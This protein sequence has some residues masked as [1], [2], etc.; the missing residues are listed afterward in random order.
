MSSPRRRDRL[1]E[2]VRQ[3]V[4]SILLTEM[5]DPRLKGVTVTR[6]EVS[7]DIQHA[8]IYIRVFGTEGKGRSALTALKNASGKIRAEVG[9]RLQTRYNP[10]LQF[11]IDESVDKE[12]HLLSL[13]QQIEKERP[14]PSDGEEEAA[15]EAKDGE[16]E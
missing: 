1:S 3:E 6:A 12:R 15:P 13:F 11:F 7:D 16:S 8:K 4:A 10:Y 5:T 2:F 9:K 14:K